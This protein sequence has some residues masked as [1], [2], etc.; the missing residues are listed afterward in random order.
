MNLTVKIQGDKAIQQELK[1]LAK[2]AGVVGEDFADYAAKVA[3]GAV[4]RNVQPFGPPN[5]KGKPK[6]MGENAVWRSLHNTFKIVGNNYQGTDLVSGISEAHQL[7]QAARNH[8]GRVGHKRAFR[9]K[10]RYDLFQR[11]GKTVID[12]VGKAKG[13]F[14]TGSG[15]LK[16]RVPAWVKRHKG[17]GSTKRKMMRGRVEWRFDNEQRHTN[18]E[19]VLGNNNLQKVLDM[20]E[21][22]LINSLKGKLRRLGKL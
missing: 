3:Q 7:H 2:K 4:V 18:D 8:R 1:R 13:G 9:K 14:A 20:Q 21:K 10:M 15:Q 12:K 17:G 22:M 5:K 19:Y 16:T 6:E 11:Y